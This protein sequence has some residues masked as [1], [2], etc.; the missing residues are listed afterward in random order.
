MHSYFLDRQRVVVL[1]AVFQ[2][3]YML[4]GIVAMGYLAPL[5]PAS[6][7]ALVDWID[8]ILYLS[9]NFT[10]VLFCR[11]LFKPY[12]P[13]PVLMRGLKLLPW[14]YPVFLVALALGYSSFALNTN[15]LFT[16]IIWL[17][18]AVVAF[19][20]REENKPSRRLLQGFFVFVL[21]NNSVFWVALTSSRLVSKADLG[22]VQ[23]L[24]GD[25]LVI[26]GMFALMLHLRT[27]QTLREAQ[28]G[29]LELLLIQEKFKIEQELKKQIEVQAQ[30]DD[31]TGLCNRR[32][33]LE[34]AE[35]E[36]TRAIRFKRP[37]TLLVIDIDEFK[38]INDALGHN[39]GDAVL[40]EVSSLMRET[41]RDEDI[42][43]RTGGDEFTAVIVET[44][45]KD[46][47]ELAQRL[48]TSVAEARVIRDG[49]SHTR[50]SISI[51]VAELKGRCT[52]FSSL[53]DEADRAMY[54]AKQ[55]GRNRVFVN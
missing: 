35:H 38:A 46:A 47:V 10:S 51:G 2:A 52:D 19:S 16:K 34:L 7:P 14:T 24:V 48:C 37:L 41:L 11:E 22:A 6:F 21:L 44:E 23:I 20:L 36:L 15:A 42:L 25:G 33:F 9:I 3:V 5:N 53:R 30:T 54:S 1:F 8:D 13:P 39:L 49:S 4:F 43:G 50:V 26:G 40:K 28:R 45:G 31:L 27:R 29:A 55:A 17:S 32:R 18:F 12:E